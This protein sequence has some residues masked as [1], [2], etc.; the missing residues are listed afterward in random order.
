MNDKTIIS[1]IEDLVEEEERLWARADDEPLS[2]P[3]KK[4]LEQIGV[5]LDRYYDLLRQ[6]R[7]R[8]ES[9]QNPD[10]AHLRSAS[11]VEGYVE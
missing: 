6:R 10:G 2:G 11:M 7:A 4:R 9:G 5:Q 1:H 8:R 3:D